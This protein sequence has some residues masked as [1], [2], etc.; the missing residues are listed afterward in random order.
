MFKRFDGSRQSAT[1][2]KPATCDE[3]P[4]DNDLRVLEWQKNNYGPPQSSVTVAG[5]N[6]VY[7]VAGSVT[8]LQQGARWRD[9]ENLFLVLLRERNA[10]D[11]HVS[12]KPGSN[13]APRFL[14]P[15]RPEQSGRGW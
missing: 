8:T 11:R 7:V 2:R 1:K 4:I 12:D 6:H 15:T 9:V 3:E 14:P 10:Q 5:R 13:Y